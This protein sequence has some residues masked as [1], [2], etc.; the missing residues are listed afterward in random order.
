M[1]H[2]H[3]ENHDIEE[4][5]TETFIIMFII[6]IKEVIMCRSMSA[7]NAYSELLVTNDQK[8]AND[9]I[10]QEKTNMLDRKSF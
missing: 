7:N 3:K 1:I 6:Y 9:L 2:F 5:N 10:L 8:I 4:T